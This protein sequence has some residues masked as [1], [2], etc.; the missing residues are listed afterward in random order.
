MVSGDLEAGV[1]ELADQ[2]LRPVAGSDV[3]GHVEVDPPAE[4]QPAAFEPGQLRTL[5]RRVKEW[6]TAIVRRLVLGVGGEAEQALP[7]TE[8]CVAGS[9]A[10]G[11]PCAAPITD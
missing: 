2:L 5:R 9:D 3:A 11:I 7:A 10:A 1:P 4:H 8:K 6:R